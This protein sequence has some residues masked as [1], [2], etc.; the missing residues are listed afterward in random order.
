MSGMKYERAFR[1]WDG[2][3]VVDRER[4][5]PVDE[6]VEQLRNSMFGAKIDQAVRER[7]TMKPIKGA[8]P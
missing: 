6:R 4:A 7:V 3:R 5:K 1:V 2:P 8:K